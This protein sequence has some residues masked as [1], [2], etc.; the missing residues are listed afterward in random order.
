M[1]S[2]VAIFGTLG[3]IF[4]ITVFSPPLVVSITVSSPLLV[5]S[6]TVLSLLLAV[7]ITVISPMLLDQ[8]SIEITV[9]C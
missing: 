9:Q 7:S 3:A 4:I 1:G 6:I 5:D 8:Q 2:L